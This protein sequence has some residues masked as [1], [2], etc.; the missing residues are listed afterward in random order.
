MRETIIRMATDVLIIGGGGA[1]ARAAMEATKCGATVT[2]VDKGVFGRSGSTPCSGGY[3]VA[4]GPPGSPEYESLLTNAA[5]VG[6]NMCDRPLLEAVVGDGAKRLEELLELGFKLEEEDNK[7]VR[8]IILGHSKPHVVYFDYRFCDPQ[9]ILRRETLNRGVQV[10]EGVMVSEL[11][12]SDQGVRG[13]VGIDEAGRIL[14]FQA[15]AVVLAAGSATRLYPFASASFTTTGDSINLAY[16]AG[17]PLVGLEFTEMTLTP[18]YQGLFL[19]SGGGGGV[20]SMIAYNRLGERFMEKYDARLEKSPRHIVA[21]AI[22]TEKT[23]GNNPF[24]CVQSGKIS[25]RGD[26]SVYRRKRLAGGLDWL[27]QEFDWEIALHRLLGGVR[28]DEHAATSLPGLF[29]AGEATGA[30]HG[31]ARLPGMALA[32]NN[33]MGARAGHSAAKH[34]HKTGSGQ[35]ISANDE[36]EKLRSLV[37]LKGGKATPMEATNRVQDAMWRGVGVIRDEAGLAKA[38]EELAAIEATCLSEVAGTPIERLEVR[39]LAKAGRLIALAGL[40]RK[41]SRANH[42]RK[43]FPG[44]NDGP[45]QH[46]LV[47]K[48]PQGPAIK[49]HPVRH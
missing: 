31:A 26:H 38:V 15:K 16:D 48:G 2:L 28:I 20:S 9:A 14:V 47:S 46:V 8:S 19:G 35:E 33:A 27:K 7:V 10:L 4:F 6:E 49:S 18:S 45:E 21:R 39:N 1:A 17:S 29:A 44:H 40:N 43:D 13:A 23:L 12:V 41:E 11:I 22:F 25:R 42:Y 5:D 24:H 34:A 32:E 30:V 3:S 36:V 37:G